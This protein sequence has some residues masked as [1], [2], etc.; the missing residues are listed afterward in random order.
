MLRTFFLTGA[1]IMVVSIN[2]TALPVA[3]TRRSQ[4]D[5]RTQSYEGPTSAYFSFSEK[6]SGEV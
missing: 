1:L 5:S 4:Q 3:A 2:H 6:S